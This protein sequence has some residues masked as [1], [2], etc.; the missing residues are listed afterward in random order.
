MATALAKVAARTAEELARHVELEDDSRAALRPGMRPG[1][2]LDALVGAEAFPD[3]VRFLAHG[4]PRRE[5]VWWACICA[6][7]ALPPTPKPGEAA[8]LEAAERWVYEPT[9]KHRRACMAAAEPTGYEVP[10]AWA[11]M[12]GFWSGGSVAPENAP[13]VPPGDWHTA[14][15]VAGSVVLAA[16]QREP[17]KA[18]SRYALFLERGVDIANGGDGMGKGG[19]A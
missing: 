11:A 1:D 19:R 4:L 3:A 13:P 15:A 5:A 9:E 17:E 10:S 7:L 16:V 8:A 14:K 2:F 12:G 18:Q 6:R